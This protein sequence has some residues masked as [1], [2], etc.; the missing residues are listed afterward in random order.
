LSDAPKVARVEATKEVPRI[1]HE[2]EVNDFNGIATG[3]E[4]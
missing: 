1:L 3:D 2:S 4:P